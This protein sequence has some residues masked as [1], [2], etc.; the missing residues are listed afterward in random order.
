M[1]R[2]SYL[3]KTHINMEKLFLHFIC[4][5]L[6]WC[7]SEAD[8]A[9]FEIGKIEVQ[10]LKDDITNCKVLIIIINLSCVTLYKLFIS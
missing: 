7:P 8:V 3:T 5:L 1:I 4:V 9:N 6:I 10:I 2:I